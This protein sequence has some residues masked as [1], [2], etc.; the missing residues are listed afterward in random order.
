M[1]GTNLATFFVS[2]NAQRILAN[3]PVLGFVTD[4]STSHVPETVKLFGIERG[5]GVLSVAE[6][7]PATQ[8]IP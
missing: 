3:L 6:I 8:V 1:S 2:I 7:T 5:E 4:T